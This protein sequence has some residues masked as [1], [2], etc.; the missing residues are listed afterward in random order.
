[1]DIISVDASHGGANHDSFI[2]N[3]H[4]VKAYMENLSR[5]QAIWLL[6]NK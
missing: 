5:T 1:M 6:G 3:H 2:W 4:P